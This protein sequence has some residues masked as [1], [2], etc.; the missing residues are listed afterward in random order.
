MTV[1]DRCGLVVVLPWLSLKRHA[2]LGSVNQ[3]CGAFVLLQH[4]S[5]RVS[6][7]GCV[8]LN[9]VNFVLCESE[10]CQLCAVCV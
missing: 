1:L 4:L 6:T 5:D 3:H 7:L 2:R 10:Q 8:C 9:S